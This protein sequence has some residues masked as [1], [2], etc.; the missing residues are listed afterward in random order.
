MENLYCT[1][2]IVDVSQN[3]EEVE[4]VTSRITQLIEDHGGIIKKQNPWGK[5]RLA[6]PIENKT[7]GFYVEI[8]F[9]A[10]SRLNIPQI[11]EKEFRLNDRVMR[12]LTYVVTKAELRQR[13]LSARRAK[14]EETSENGRS[15][16]GKAPRREVKPR[17]SPPKPVTK[18]PVAVIE[19]S[20][21][22]TSPEVVGS[23]KPAIKT[24]ETETSPE[25]VVDEKPAIET[26]EADTAG[27]EES[28]D[29]TKSDET[30]EKEEV[31]DAE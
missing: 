21:T 24:P 15:G 3:P 30:T 4:T 10:Q 20:E 23:E 17:V 9:T 16:M 12:Y 14:S 7:S 8:E 2:Y 22:E 11:I 5:R 1:I 26:P 29:A 27:V 28:A 25:V 19:K 13:R 31:K 18:E 6:Y